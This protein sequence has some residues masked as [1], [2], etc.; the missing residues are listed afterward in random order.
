[1]DGFF[2]LRTIWSN[3]EMESIG[4]SNIN[5]ERGQLIFIRISLKFAFLDDI[6]T[7]SSDSIDIFILCFLG[8]I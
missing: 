4:I 8:M 2:A 5:G 6:G 7:A 3:Y 1:M